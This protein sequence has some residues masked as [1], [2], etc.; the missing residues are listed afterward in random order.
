MD[1]RILA[2]N[3]KRLRADKNMSQQALAEASGMS[4]PAIK[5]LEGLKSAPRAHTLTQ[6]TRAL[7]ASFQ[8]LFSPLRTLQS[9]RFRAR[10]R[11]LRRD[12]ILAKTARWLDDFNLLE[13]MMDDTLKYKLEK[14]AWPPEQKADPIK[15]AHNVRA[16]LRLKGDEPIYDICGLLEHAGIKLLPHPYASDTFFGLSVGPQDKGPAIIV[17]T[18]KLII[19]ERQILSAAHELGHL[20]MHLS[21]YNGGDEHEDTGQ[22]KEAD[23][24]AGHFLMPQ[25]GFEKE[26]HYTA[27]LYYI[28]R[29]MK[30]KRIFKVSYKAVLYR[31]IQRD[32]ADE[33]IWAK[34]KTDFERHY[35]KRLPHKTE[36][37]GI[38][39][40]DFYVDRLDRLTREA[41]EKDVISISRGAEI[42]G[43]ST[44]DMLERVKTW[45]TYT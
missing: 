3:L 25:E 24:F 37:Y 12:Q 41:I 45:K 44:E 10:K 6:L 20:L 22:E 30:V 42:L 13:K 4:L 36:P 18:W 11:I 29:I 19:T 14:L 27:G 7:E 9:V 26:W 17:N 34:F 35:D 8:E 40:F 15:L 2:A 33:N 31:L 1:T 32:M 23:L 38:Q 16:A 5:K 21:E 43:L 28:D 39:R